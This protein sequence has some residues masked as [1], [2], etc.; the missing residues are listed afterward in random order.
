MF[1]FRIL[2][3]STRV[4]YLIGAYAFKFPTL[5]EWRLFL[6]GLLAN[7]QERLWAKTGWSELCPIVWSIPGGWLVVMKRTESLTREQYENFDVVSFLNKEEYIIPT[8][9]KQDSFG[10]YKGKIVSIDYGN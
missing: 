3:G 10:W 1:N 2:Y 6:N 5:V 4:V 7:M 9:D 8:E